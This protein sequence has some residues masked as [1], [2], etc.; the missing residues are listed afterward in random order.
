VKA[1]VQTVMDNT[2]PSVALFF[3]LNNLSFASKNE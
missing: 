2:A 1:K 3:H